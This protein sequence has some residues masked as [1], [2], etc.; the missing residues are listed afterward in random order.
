MFMGLKQPAIPGIWGSWDPVEGQPKEP[1]SDWPQYSVADSETVPRAQQQ[2]SSINSAHASAPVAGIDGEQNN[3]SHTQMKPASRSFPRDSDSA[4]TYPS[5]VKSLVGLGA[6]NINE[7]DSNH[8]TLAPPRIHAAPNRPPSLQS[9]STDLCLPAPPSVPAHLFTA[10]SQDR[11]TSPPPPPK[12]F[13]ASTDL[14]KDAAVKRVI[15]TTQNNN[16]NGPMWGVASRPP[17]TFT[18]DENYSGALSGGVEARMDDGGDQ[19]GPSTTRA[20][21]GP[22]AVIAE[23]EGT[24]IQKSSAVRSDARGTVDG[25]NEDEAEAPARGT[26]KEKDKP[27]GWFGEGSIWNI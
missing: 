21:T 6:S 25:G 17:I 14:E 4:P 18:G 24:A 3:T 12:H 19:R 15:S 9:I 22:G 27:R 16:D 2:L 11:Y 23:E 1:D 10:T 13:N 8:I 20:G 7:N 5:E 26:G